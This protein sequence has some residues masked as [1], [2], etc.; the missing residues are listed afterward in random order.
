MHFELTFPPNYPA[1]PPK[2]GFL[3]EIPFSTGG[4]FRDARGRQTLCLSILGDLGNVHTEWAGPQQQR[5]GAHGWSPGTT[6]ASLLVNLHAL[7][8]SGWLFQLPGRLPGWRRHRRCLGL[9]PRGFCLRRHTCSQSRR[10]RPLL[11]AQRTHPRQM[12]KG[13]GALGS[14]GTHASRFE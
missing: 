7:L 11:L 12:G 14:G 10:V 1:S 9:G 2:A 3:T 8:L 4:S 6:I 5:G 13:G